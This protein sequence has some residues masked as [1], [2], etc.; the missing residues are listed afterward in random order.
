[1][2]PLLRAEGGEKEP[3]VGPELLAEE[4]RLTRQRR[5][6]AL[7]GECGEPCQGWGEATKSE[8]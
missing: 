1:L 4:E 2:V 8:R 3:Q 7:C 5:P 6:L